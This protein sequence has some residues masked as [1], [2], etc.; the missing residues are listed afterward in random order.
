MT[1]ATLADVCLKCGACWLALVAGWE[2]QISKSKRPWKNK[3]AVLKRRVKTAY[4]TRNSK[5]KQTHVCARMT[6]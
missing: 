5:E 6:Q 1:G 4:A 2:K 3:H